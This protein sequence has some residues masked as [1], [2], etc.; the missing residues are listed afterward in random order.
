MPLS[1]PPGLKGREAR[2]DL[3][4]SPLDNFELVS[5][6]RNPLYCSSCARLSKLDAPSPPLIVSAKEV[7]SNQSSEP[8]DETAFS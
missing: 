1:S 5:R 7:S 3:R 4:V 8:R 6:K 2:S